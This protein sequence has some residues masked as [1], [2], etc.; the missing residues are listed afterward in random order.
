VVRRR[1]G[2]GHFVEL[3][4]DNESKSQMADLRPGLPIMFRW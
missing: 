3:G 2:A 1:A 4:F